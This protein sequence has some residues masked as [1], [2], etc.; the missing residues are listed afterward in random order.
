MIHCTV[1]LKISYESLILGFSRFCLVYSFDHVLAELHPAH[2]G[3]GH[4]QL[5]FRSVHLV[6]M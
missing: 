6:D 5:S 3:I 1:Y 2:R 4:A